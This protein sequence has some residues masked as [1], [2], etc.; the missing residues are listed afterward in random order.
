MIDFL[1]GHFKYPLW[2]SW[3]GVSSFANKVKIHYMQLPSEVMDAAWDLLQDEYDSFWRQMRLR[4]E[5]FEKEQRGY[6]NVY[7]N[8]RSS[9]YLVLY[10]KDKTSLDNHP[11][12]YED[13]YA[14]SQN[15]LVNRVELVQSFD[16]LCDEIREDLIYGLQ[17][18]KPLM[19]R[20][21]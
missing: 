1:S 21:V 3:N 16:R 4:L 12:E 17:Y 10:P 8:G 13:K 20:V 7:S 2:N 11:D 5:Q 19:R 15:D 6:Y 18:R 9:G 14:W